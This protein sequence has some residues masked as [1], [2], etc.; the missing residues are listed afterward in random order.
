V[1]QDTRL[2]M[3]VVDVTGNIHQALTRGALSRWLTPG[4]RRPL[5]PPGAPPAVAAVAPA[6]SAAAAARQMTCLR[7]GL[8]D[9]ARHVI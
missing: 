9:I 5:P 1:T 3:R 7:Q 2:I 4:W 8:A 6:A